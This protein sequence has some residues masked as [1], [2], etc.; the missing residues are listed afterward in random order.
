MVRYGQVLSL[1]VYLRAED[2]DNDDDVG[3]DAGVDVCCVV[4]P[5]SAVALESIVGASFAASARTD[6]GMLHSSR[7]RVQLRSG[8]PV[9]S[10]AWLHFFEPPSV[11]EEEHGVGHE[12][13]GLVG[14]T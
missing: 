3:E 10:I 8:V 9:V 5:K 14:A 13:L 2:N 4:A 6:V 7:K 11:V 1:L 12:E